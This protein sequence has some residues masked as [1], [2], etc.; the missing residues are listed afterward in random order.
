MG[1][2]YAIRH[3]EKGAGSWQPKAGTP[4]ENIHDPWWQVNRQSGQLRRALSASS[5]SSVVPGTLEV[6]VGVPKDTE[7][8]EYARFVIYGTSKMVPRNF[9]MNTT[10]ENLEALRSLICRR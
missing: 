4:A 3:Y 1:H 10:F 6:R 8:Y 5:V 9:I 2:P 7:A